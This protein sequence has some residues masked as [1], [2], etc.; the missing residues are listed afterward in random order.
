MVNDA[1]AAAIVRWRKVTGSGDDAE[2]AHAEL[3]ALLQEAFLADDGEPGADRSGQVA[4]PLQRG[5]C[6]VVDAERVWDEVLRSQRR[7]A[8]V[9]R[10]RELRNV[11]DQNRSW[12]WAIIWTLSG[13][14]RLRS[15]PAHDAGCSGLDRSCSL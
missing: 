4:A 10:L 14:S 2:D 6:S 7:W 12:L 9:R 3:D 5:L 1:S 11:A 13:L 8:D 15:C